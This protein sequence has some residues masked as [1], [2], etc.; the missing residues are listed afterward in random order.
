MNKET[1][2]KITK[3]PQNYAK[4]IDIEELVNTL[5]I[6]SDAYYNTG[7]SLVSDEVYDVLIDVLKER[8]PKNFYI[9]V[10]TV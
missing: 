10:A 3:E 1:L 7:E 4:K 5:T 6:L 8:D 9:L 2:K